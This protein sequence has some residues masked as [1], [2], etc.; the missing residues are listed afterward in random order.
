MCM[1]MQYVAVLMACNSR[2]SYSGECGGCGHH[3]NSNL[4]T[5][6]EHALLLDHTSKMMG[7]EADSFQDNRRY[8]E[9]GRR[10]EKLIRQESPFGA[11]V[12]GLNIAHI[13]Q[14]RANPKLVG[15]VCVGGGV[16]CM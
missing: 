9:E 5:P 13:D 6:E 4:L 10:L 7:R 12:D 16:V 2:R 14:K 3:L 1:C 11:V 15:V 8:L